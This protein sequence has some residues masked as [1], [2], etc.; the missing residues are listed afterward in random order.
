MSEELTTK[1]RGR[2]RLTEEEKK[3]RA[4][5]RKSGELQSFKRP[6]QALRMSEQVE[7]GDNARYLA[8]AMVTMNLPK[9][10]T[11]DPK[12]VEERI[13]WYLCHCVDNDMKPTVKGFCNALGISRNTLWEWKTGRARPNT[14]E[15]IVVRAYDLLEEMWENY[16]QNGKIN[17]MA[18]V[19][20]GVNNFGY[21]DVKQVNVTPVVNNEPEVI[22]VATI[23]AKYAELPED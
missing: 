5:K 7:S 8:H 1:K 21:R 18:G 22:D 17:P 10:D 13:Q 16:M 23:E 19:F 2:P 11:S 4:A 3:E 9:I 6:D 14:H 12:Q 15:E 20:L